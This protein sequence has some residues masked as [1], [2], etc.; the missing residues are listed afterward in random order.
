MKLKS[1]KLRNGLLYAIFI[2][3]T[4]SFFFASDFTYM[5]KLI[6]RYMNLVLLI[7]LL[8]FIAREKTIYYK[9]GVG[10]KLDKH[11]HNSPLDIF[12]YKIY[13]IIENVFI[14]T[15]AG[16]AI[17]RVIFNDIPNIMSYWYWMAFGMYIAGDLIY[18][19]YGYLKRYN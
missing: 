6:L 16:V 10:V 14:F 3:S 8:F 18:F 7:L 19:A 17:Y 9:S 2:S 15:F 4:I 11:L 12:C 1:C 5:A 13:T